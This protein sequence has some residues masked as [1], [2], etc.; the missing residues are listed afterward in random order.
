M[1]NVSRLDMENRSSEW[2]VWPSGTSTAI[3]ADLPSRKERNAVQNLSW[4]QDKPTTPGN[5]NIFYKVIRR[6]EENLFSCTAMEGD[7]D[8]VEYKIGEWAR[9][10]HRCGPLC[11]FEKLLSAQLFAQG[12]TVEIYKCRIVRSKSS[13]VWFRP[14]SGKMGMYIM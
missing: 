5:E 7:S 2:P 11:V 4:P 6:H 9:P 10:N 1:Q 14:P 8:C 12:R 3:S 13:Y